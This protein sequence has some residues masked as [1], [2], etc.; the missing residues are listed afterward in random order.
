MR[1]KKVN[2]LKRGAYVPIKSFRIQD[3]L[4]PKLWDDFEIDSQ[5]KKQLLTIAKDF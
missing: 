3:N 2:E 1:L 4:N 5:V